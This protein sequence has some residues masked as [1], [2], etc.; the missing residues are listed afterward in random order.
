MKPLRNIV[1]N[2]RLNLVI[3]KILFINNNIIRLNL[4]RFKLTLIKKYFILNNNTI[5][6][7]LTLIKKYFIINNNKIIIRFKCYKI[8][9][10][11]IYRRY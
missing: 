3:K 6:F 8:F 7:N 2:N 11:W 1:H 4:I 5:R 9:L 10:K